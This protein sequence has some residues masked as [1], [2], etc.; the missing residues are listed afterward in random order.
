VAVTILAMAVLA[1]GGCSAAPRT[2]PPA[3]SVLV[4]NVYLVA[5][6]D[7]FMPQEITLKALAPVRLFV[8]SFDKEYHIEIPD[9]R[10]SSMTVSPFSDT[11][12]SFTPVEAGSFVFRNPFMPDM[13]GTLIVQICPPD[14]LA[15][16]NPIPTSE[17]SVAVGREVYAANCAS[18]H[19]ID[20]RGGGPDAGQLT[21][22]PIDLTQPYMD[23]I[24]DGEMF[25]A[26]EQGLGEMPAFRDDLSDDMKWHVINYIRSL[27]QQ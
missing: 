21:T 3:P 7:R 16:Q 13:K 5:N 11:V 20:G 8:T 6:E 1:I 18:C 24:K 15:R 10:V 17:G 26:I 25:W 9:M 4:Q 22:R 2:Q 12:I 14:Y 23:T 27:R 19:G